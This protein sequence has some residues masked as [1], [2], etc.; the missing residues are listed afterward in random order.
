MPLFFFFV[1][2]PNI[3]L[4]NLG[5]KNKIQTQ[6]VNAEIN[7]NT[8]TGCW[9]KRCAARQMNSLCPALDKLIVIPAVQVMK[10]PQHHQGLFDLRCW[11]ISNTACHQ[12]WFQPR[13]PQLTPDPSPLL[14]LRK[15]AALNFGRL[16]VF[17]KPICGG[18]G[19]GGPLGLRHLGQK[20]EGVGWRVTDWRTRSNERGMALC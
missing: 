14:P 15:V 1:Q 4:S 11:H 17:L 10:S 6:S 8:C 18:G 12:S 13:V 19:V 7:R 3:F 5:R 16:T 9:G 20:E 2:K